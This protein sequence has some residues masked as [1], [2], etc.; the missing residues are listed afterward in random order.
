MSSNFDT[1]LVENGNQI[2]NGNDGQIGLAV[3]SDE[4][5]IF[6]KQLSD[7]LTNMVH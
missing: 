7:L 5:C 4:S 1:N 3:T 6:P 2:D